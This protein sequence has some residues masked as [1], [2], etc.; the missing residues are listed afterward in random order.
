MKLSLICDISFNSKSSEIYIHIYILIKS[1][2]YVRQIA[3]DQSGNA[4]L[5]YNLATK[6]NRRKIVNHYTYAI[7]YL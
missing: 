7:K 4:M 5:M 2:L 6:C 3:A 1:I